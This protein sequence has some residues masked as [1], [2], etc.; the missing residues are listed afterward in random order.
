LKATQGHRTRNP[1]TSFLTAANL[2]YAIGAGITAAAGQKQFLLIKLK[3][4]F[5]LFFF[6]SGK[7]KIKKKEE[8]AFN[9]KKKT[10]GVPLVLVLPKERKHT[11]Q[12]SH[13]LSQGNRA[14]P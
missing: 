8:K 3:T 12:S 1:T 14:I 2:I 10:T 7:K 11:N 4:F 6:I 9:L 13:L 5:F